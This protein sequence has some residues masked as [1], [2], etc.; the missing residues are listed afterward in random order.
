MSSFARARLSVRAAVAVAVIA[1]GGTVA[2]AAAA[3]AGAAGFTGHYAVTRSLCAQPSDPAQFRCFAMERVPVAAGTRG[4]YK[5]AL[6]H[7]HIGGYSPNDLAKAYGY[8]ANASVSQTVGIVDWYD[9]PYVARDLNTFDQAYGLP[10]ETSRSFRKVNQSGHASPLP[11]ASRDST[12]TALDVQAVRAVCHKCRILLVEANNPSSSDLAAAENTAVR[13]GANEVS[14]SFG[15]AESGATAGMISA[16]RH[17]G[18]VITA[19]T[20]DD[21]WYGWDGWNFAQ[22]PY[23]TDD[24]ASF[25]ASDPYV[26]SVGGT[27]LTVNSDGS[28]ADETVW[29]NNGDAD[30]A[31]LQEGPQGATGGGCSNRFTAGSW[32][33]HVLNYASTGCG[34]DG[35]G[36]VAADVAALAD[37]R[38]GFDV[39]DRYGQGGWITVGGTSLS[40]PVI[41]AMYA[42]AGGSGGSAYPA[43]SLYI[44]SNTANTFDVQT[45]GNGFC[46]D[47]DAATCGNDVLQESGTY[48]N[49]NSWA[50]SRVDCSFDPTDAPGQCN[51]AQGYDGPSGLGTPKGLGLFQP[52][53]GVGYLSVPTLARLR[54]SQ[55]FTAH[56]WERL[57]GAAFTTFAWHWGDGTSTT[58]TS[59]STSHTYTRAGHYVVSVTVSDTLHQVIVRSHSFTVGMLPSVHYSGSTTLRRGHSGAFTDRGSH[60]VNTG[61]HIASVV[62]HWGDGHSTTASSAHHTYAHTG[63]YTVTLTIKDTSGV[64]RSVHHSVRVTS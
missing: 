52:T 49:P 42:L 64:S 15:G 21:G 55:A 23:D 14:N 61:A 13:L 59:A 38:Y 8:N 19:S 12:E 39:L 48:S 30:V 20:G 2:V 47:V 1:A 46:G 36:R 16:F 6:G 22:D 10:V 56:V 3:P 60:A 4:A 27:R 26:V 29:N 44:N 11:R 24:E 17:P 51:A 54:Q 58:S 9:D 18:V 53:S 63:T 33:W 34:S 37:P 7:G 31:G 25:P 43:A 41:A 50:Q 35:H 45:G 28:R 32:Q 57:S 40:S 62:W 5:V